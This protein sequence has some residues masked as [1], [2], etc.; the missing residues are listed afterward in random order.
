MSLLYNLVHREM[1]SSVQLYSKKSCVFSLYSTILLNLL[2]ECLYPIEGSCFKIGFTVCDDIVPER[3]L[4][5]DIH[6]LQTSIYCSYICNFQEDQYLIK[7]TLYLLNLHTACMEIGISQFIYIK[8]VNPTV[9]PSRDYFALIS[10]V[11]FVM[12]QDSSPTFLFR[13]TFDLQVF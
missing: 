11:L 8:I 5:K 1:Y 2:D 9:Q 12:S 4:R 3:G 10:Q 13:V 6:V 7:S